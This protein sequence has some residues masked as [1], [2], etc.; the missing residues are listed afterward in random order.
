ML[1]ITSFC[2]QH[3]AVARF[4]LKQWFVYDW[5]YFLA[6]MYNVVCYWKTAFFVLWINKF[7]CSLKTSVSLVLAKLRVLPHLSSG[8]F[9]ERN[10]SAR[11]NHPTREKATRCGERE[12]WERE[13]KDTWSQVREEL[14]RIR[15][16]LAPRAVGFDMTSLEFK[17]QN[18][19]SSWDFTF[20][21]YKSSWK[22]IF[23]QIFAS[24]GF[25]VL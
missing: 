3:F 24:K 10:A 17:Q 25:L 22:L 5:T 1:Y 13:L 12:K 7:K 21:L 18:Y 6:E 16:S 4:V 9:N 19:R 20:M 15:K 14:D 23:K 8:I 11:E 2:M